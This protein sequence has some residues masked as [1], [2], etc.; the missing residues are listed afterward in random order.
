MVGGH[1]IG[2]D[3]YYLSYLAKKINLNPELILAG[4]KTNNSMVNF[5]QKSINKLLRVRK[6][7]KAKILFMGL[8]FK[9]N[10]NDIRNSK[11]LELF[12]KLNKKHYVQVYDP[13]IDLNIFKKRYKIFNFSKKINFDC[14]VIAVKHDE[15]KSISISKFKEIIKKH[16]FIIDLM[17]YFDEKNQNLNY[18]KNEIWKL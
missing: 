15:F 11:N 2:V 7:S 9:E 14:I 4:R 1:C 17:N 6:I 12:E 13:V 16:G 10:C 8:S 18:F 5:V 3:P